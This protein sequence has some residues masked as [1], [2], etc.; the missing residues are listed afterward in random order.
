VMCIVGRGGGAPSLIPL[1]DRRG[2]AGWE[3]ISIRG[4]EL[5]RDVYLLWMGSRIKMRPWP[6][7]G[8][9]FRWGIRMSSQAR[10]RVSRYVRPAN[11][12]MRPPSRHVPRDHYD[13]NGRTGLVLRV[14]E[15]SY[16]YGVVFV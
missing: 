8:V 15:T 16:A 2:E 11:I 3:G 14:G 7:I 9:R 1:E 13:Q 10:Y 5:D 4:W 12:K 6:D